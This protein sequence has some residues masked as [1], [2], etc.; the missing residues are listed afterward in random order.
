MTE[1]T[2]PAF[3]LNP[4]GFVGYPTNHVYG[5]VD[6]PANHVPQIMADLLALDIDTEAIHIY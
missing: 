5:I 1:H 2:E 3:N 6:D 4:H